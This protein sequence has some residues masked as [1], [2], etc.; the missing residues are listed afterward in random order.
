MTS[1]YKCLYIHI[2]VY[3]EHFVYISIYIKIRC[4]TR[5]CA[6]L[7]RTKVEGIYSIPRVYDID[8]VGH[9]RLSLLGGYNKKRNIARERE[10]E[11]GL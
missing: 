7:F 11:E 1:E 8:K 4:Q 10:R 6:F 5:V 2:N 9:G 3:K